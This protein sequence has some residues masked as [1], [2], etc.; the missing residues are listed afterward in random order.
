M[1]SGPPVRILGALG[2][3]A[4]LGCALP[5]PGLGVPKP[6]AAALAAFRIAWTRPEGVYVARGDGS[7]AR[8]LVPAAHLEAGEVPFLASLGPRGDRVLFVSMTGRDPR[9]GR[10]RSLALHV[11]LL[12]GDRRGAWRRVRLD[13]MLGGDPGSAVEPAMVPAAAWSPGGSRIAL[14][15]RREAH[16]ATDALLVADAQGDPE[17]LVDLAEARLLAGSGLAWSAGED[18]LLVSLATPEEGEGPAAG[19]ITR[20]GLAGASA[21]A[22]WDPIAKGRDPALSPDG[23][24]LAVVDAAG[25]S[26]ADIVLID[27][28]GRQIDRF[29]RPAGRGL[30]HLFWSPDGR[31]LYYHSLASTGPLGI[32]EIGLLRCLD[33][34]ARRVYDLVRLG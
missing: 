16:G 14:G 8:R 10:G 1:M 31:Y 12:D 9:T 7:D 4:F 18:A 5:A 33:T 32:V 11:I 19:M 34:R 17:R 24:R 26:T 30:N 3:A 15:L 27:L 6:D 21:A 25:S 28:E 2:A 20:V 22:G 13:R 29:E 23:R